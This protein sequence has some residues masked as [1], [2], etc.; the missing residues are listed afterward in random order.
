[1]RLC[2]WSTVLPLCGT[3]TSSG[4]IPTR[5]TR[6]QSKSANIWRACDSFSVVGYGDVDVALA[7]ANVRA[8]L[9]DDHE[10]ES[11]QRLDCFG[12]GDVARKFHAG[13]TTKSLT[14]CNRMLE[15]KLALWK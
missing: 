8:I 5:H 2:T 4:G 9:W 14:R 10:G 3:Q 13:A 7:Q 12:A 1:M 11:P 6:C 15:G